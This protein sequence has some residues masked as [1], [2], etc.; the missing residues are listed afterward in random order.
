MNKKALDIVKDSSRYVYVEEPGTL[1]NLPA[2]RVI[3]TA[4]ER[5]RSRIVEIFHKREDNTALTPE[6]EELWR[7]FGIQ[8]TV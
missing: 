6:E 2:M 3:D 8:T 4:F 7:E 1:G 5:V